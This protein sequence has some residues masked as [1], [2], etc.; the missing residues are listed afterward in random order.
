MLDYY[1]DDALDLLISIQREM[2][3]T[4][5]RGKTLWIKWKRLVPL[6][7]M[8]LKNGL[9]DNQMIWPQA[10]ISWGPIY[11]LINPIMRWQTSHINLSKWFSMRDF[12]DKLVKD[13]WKQWYELINARCQV[14][15]CTMLIR[16]CFQYPKIKVRKEI[17]VVDACLI[18]PMY[19]EQIPVI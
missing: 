19:V 11:I 7:G 15:V 9:S 14:C 2:C 5:S 13:K 6:R 10:R 4:N 16:L 12:S 3:T 8:E 17:K 18:W 1:D